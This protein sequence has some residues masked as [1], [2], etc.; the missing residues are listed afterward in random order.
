MLNIGTYVAI[1]MAPH[2]DA[3]ADHQDRLD[4]RRQR[5]D[6]RVT[7]SSGAQRGRTIRRAPTYA[8]AYQPVRRLSLTTS[9][10]RGA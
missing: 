5:L 4:D 3:H 1:T 6:A 2:R 7:S 9:P 10:L 8:E